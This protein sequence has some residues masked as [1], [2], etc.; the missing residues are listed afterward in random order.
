M[1]ST[2]TIAVLGYGNIGKP[3]VEALSAAGAVVLVLSRDASKLSGVPSTARA[4]SVD[5]ADEVKLGGLF[6]EHS[7]DIVVSTLT[8]SA[9]S[10]VQVA[11]AR[12]A[13]KAGV[14]LFVPSEY[15]ISTEGHTG[16]SLFGAK[17]ASAAQIQA[18][19]LPTARIMTGYFME[20]I[21]FVT[22][23]AKK[24]GEFVIAG[25]G[26][27]KFTA[28]AASDI[29]GY[30]AHILTTRSF[31]DLNNS[32][33]LIE[34]QSLTFNEVAA[35]YN[36]KP[37]YVAVDAIEHPVQRVLL[38]ALNA[39]W[40]KTGFDITKPDAPFEVVDARSRSSNALWP[41]HVWKQLKDVIPS[42]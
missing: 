7:V 32:I 26:D 2:R 15:G 5:Y 40:A 42:L 8:P 34:G 28:T 19:G 24:P 35:L 22:S 11:V 36:K 39:G 37:T 31:A 27:V 10:D 6:K 12:A 21:P 20:F 33:H 38:T 14:K 3:I 41:G 30:I 16:D 1:S 17:N 18:L 9:V 23:D 4:F 29:A 13:K 25:N